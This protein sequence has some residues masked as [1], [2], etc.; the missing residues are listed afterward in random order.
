MK[1]VGLGLF[2]WRFF[3]GDHIDGIQRTDASWFGR[4]T[5]PD[6]HVNWWSS[7]P[8][9]TRLMI[10][11][12]CVFGIIGWF[13]TFDYSPVFRV[14]LVLVLTILFAPYLFH[15]GVL[16]V[17]KRLPIRTVVIVREIIHVEHVDSEL[18][19]IVTDPDTVKQLLDLDITNEIENGINNVP[20]KPRTRRSS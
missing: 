18:D 6:H 5:K 17:V 20:P 14:N 8:R 9:F 11:C 13:V 15:H 3:T 16:F 1:K 7:K 2:L 12:G 4:G 10:R 19:N